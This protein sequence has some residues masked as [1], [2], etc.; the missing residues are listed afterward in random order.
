MKRKTYLILLFLLILFSCKKNDPEPVL[1][2]ESSVIY[3]DSFLDDDNTWISDSTVYH[4]RKYYQKHYSIRQDSINT[5]VFSLAPYGTINFP[6]S[7]E[8]DGVIQLDDPSKTGYIGIVFNHTDNDHFSVFE[9]D[10]DGTYFIF[11]YNNGSTTN[12]APYTECPSFKKETG[13][14]NTL[15]I[16]QNA[17]KVQ[18]R[19][20]N[21]IS[22]TFQSI[23]P[24]G[25]MQAGVFVAT[26]NVNAPANLAGDLY[27]PTT[28]L[29][30]NFTVTKN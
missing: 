1:D 3:Q 30:N 8:V 18:V 26:L 16:S 12:I 20:N 11:T 17:N 19:I 23:M 28:G 9:I 27:S 24:G 21:V 7:V 2:A 6:Y 4:V 13:A 22:G 29:F 14:K 10:N 25:D 15:K 5:A